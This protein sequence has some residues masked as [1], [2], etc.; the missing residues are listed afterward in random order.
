MGDDTISVSYINRVIE[1]DLG[2]VSINKIL[3]KRE[4]E[5]TNRYHKGD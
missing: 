2:K 5:S 3:G 1:L 4:F